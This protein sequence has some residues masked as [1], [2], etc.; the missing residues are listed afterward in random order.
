MIIYRPH[1]GTLKESLSEKKEF[2]TVSDMKDYIV[3]QW[4]G[5]IE[6]EDIV[7]DYK[8]INDERIGWKD[9]KRICVNKLGNEDYMKIYGCSQCIGYYATNYSIY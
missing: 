8:E 1:R 9:T 2:E 7:I 4:N 6:K 5:F 3:I